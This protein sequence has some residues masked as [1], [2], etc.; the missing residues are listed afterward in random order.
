[1]DENKSNINNRVTC[2]PQFQKV[3]FMGSWQSTR[4]TRQSQHSNSLYYKRTVV[5]LASWTVHLPA[6]SDRWHLRRIFVKSN[7]RPW[8]WRQS[9]LPKRECTFTRLSCHISEESTH[10]KYIVRASNVTHGC[11]YKRFQAVIGMKSKVVVLSVMTP[12]NL[13]CGCQHVGG[14]W[15]LYL[16]EGTYF[17]ESI[18]QP[19][20]HILFFFRW[21]Y[22]LFIYLFTSYA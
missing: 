21:M 19:S 18:S 11:I 2:Y 17:T 16:T 4:N 6:I 20:L 22:F 5:S 15:Y 1:M 14:T 12:C 9:I 10:H 13:I 3:S 8:R 7:C